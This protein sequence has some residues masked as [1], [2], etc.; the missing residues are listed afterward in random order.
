MTSTIAARRV[1]ARRVA[2]GTITGPEPA[3][4]AHVPLIPLP[5]AASF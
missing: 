5:N 1:A 4:D 2:G 3:Q